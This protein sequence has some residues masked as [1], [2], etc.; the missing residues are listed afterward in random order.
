M[1]GPQQLSPELVLVDAN[2]RAVAIAALPDRVWEK[3][4][5]PRRV[6]IAPASTGTSGS[7]LIR[8]VVLYSVWHA[9][10]GALLVCGAMVALGLTLL[11]LSF[12][13]G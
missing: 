2:L 10:L 8:V 4:A 6:A 9:L 7:S 3:Y 13:A 11:A 12:V 1:P 5:P